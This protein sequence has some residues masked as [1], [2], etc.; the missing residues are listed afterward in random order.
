MHQKTI[1]LNWSGKLLVFLTVFWGAL[2]LTACGKTSG[3]EG[4]AAEAPKG[5]KTET[6]YE[7]GNRVTMIT[8]PG[9]EDTATE[10]AESVFEFPAG[11]IELQKMT[12][13][14]IANLGIEIHETIPVQQL[15]GAYQRSFMASEKGKDVVARV[16]VIAL[17]EPTRQRILIMG[18]LPEKYD[19]IGGREALLAQFA[20]GKSLEA[21]T[22]DLTERRDLLDGTPD[23]HIVTTSSGGVQLTHNN[24]K[25]AIDVAEFMAGRKMSGD[26][27]KWLLSHVDEEW[28]KEPNLE[29]YDNVREFLKQARNSD[30]FKRLEMATALYAGSLQAERDKGE[31]SKL[32]DLVKKLNPV[33]AEKNGDIL[34]ERALEA[35]LRTA[36]T[37]MQLQ[38]KSA[39]EIDRA[40]PKLR[41]E[42]IK[43]FKR[44]PDD[45]RKALQAAESRWLRLLVTTAP[46]SPDER[47][48]KLNNAALRAGSAAST[49]SVAHA[50][51]EPQTIGGMT[52][53]Q[54]NQYMEQILYGAIVVPEFQNH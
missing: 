3:A 2:S 21:L 38:G 8:E 23:D 49:L 46:L 18:A 6:V 29:N 25:V 53:A 26:D 28:E 30:P 17:E 4:T 36:K 33:L 35:R 13:G 9:D 52:W 31:T 47:K 32:L 27:I 37:V 51:E 10:L 15:E 54:Y 5:W 7:L 48:K 16:D 12:D 19:R 1:S 11:L 42:I 43:S 50:I 39:G 45:K 34:T 40:E 20:G 44:V 22:R 24:F 41:Q 14:F